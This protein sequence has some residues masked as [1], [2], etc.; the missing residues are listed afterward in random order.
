M[1]PTRAL[2]ELGQSLWLDHI[3]RDLLESGTLQRYV[4][5]LSVTGLTSNPTI[6]DHAIKGSTAYDAPIRDLLAKGKSGEGLFFDIALA[7]ITKAADL[8]KPVWERTSGV[9][10]FVSL[11]VSPLLAYDTKSTLAAAKDLSGRAKRPIAAVGSAS[12]PSTRREA[13]T[14]ASLISASR[15]QSR[16]R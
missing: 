15:P 14:S 11:E 5:E 1:T 3:T 10:G 6:F 13:T 2:S 8:F 16:Q 7:D 4:R 9:D 12:R